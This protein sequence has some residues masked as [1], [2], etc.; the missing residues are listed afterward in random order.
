MVGKAMSTVITVVT[1]FF[2]VRALTQAEFGLYKQVFLIY[3][4]L[5][6]II[7]L[8]LV[9]SLFY[10][11]PN[12]GEKRTAYITY[13]QRYLLLISVVTFGLLVIFR[14]AIAASMGNIF[15]SEYA[16][17]IGL[18][19]G[20]MVF[21]SA[22]EVVLIVDGRAQ[23]SAIV[24]VVS[25]ITKSL[26]LLMPVLLFHNF[27]TMMSVLIVLAVVRCAAFAIYIARTRPQDEA[28]V[29]REDR[30][31][32]FVYALP[33]GMAVMVTVIQGSLD[34]YMV[35]ATVGAAGLA[36]Y[37]VGMF[38][39]PIVSIMQHAL[40]D[41]TVPQLTL[42]RIGGQR[43]AIVVT[44]QRAMIYLSI[45]FVPLCLLLVVLREEFIEVLFTAAYRESVSI[46]M[47]GVF[48]LP[49]SAML[50]DAILRAYDDTRMLLGITVVSCIVVAATLYPFL[51]WFGLVGAAIT[52][53][54]ALA[55]NR[56][57]F[58]WR[59]AKLLSVPLVDLIPWR[60]Y[61][62]IVM[63]SSVSAAIA[64]AIRQ[65]FPLTPVMRALTASI[66]FGCVYVTLLF[67]SNL[68]PD[69]YINK[70]MGHYAKLKHQIL[71]TC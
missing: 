69:T 1:P 41:V 43:Q 28:R 12:A 52:T 65:S 18:Y 3:A 20:C 70:C 35:S 27:H 56:V 5:V 19:T 30:T 49:L 32:L 16:A 48:I 64:E 66:V 67:R 7:P 51:A 38:Q 55:I 14:H 40:A 6:Q 44:W 9:P 21:S 68:L 25:D 22:L 47:V 31:Q 17:E 61:L 11:L 37:S 45:V 58:V 53:V 10:F 33:F 62:S 26:G 59:S 71:G 23:W 50:Q 8:G 63:L 4:T 60:D 2:L 39:L 46:F 15:L 36:V 34:R 29:S 13:V 42:Y 57:L 54:L 24:T